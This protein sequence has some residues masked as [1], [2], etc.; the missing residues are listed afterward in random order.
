LELK[1]HASIIAVKSTSPQT[2]DLG[3]LRRIATE[4]EARLARISGSESVDVFGD[5]G[6]EVL[7]E[8]RPDVLAALGLSTGAVARQIEQSEAQ[9]P[10]GTLRD[11]DK[12]L[13]VDV[14]TEIDSLQR[15]ERVEIQYGP[16]GRTTRLA[17]IA[18]IQRAIVDPPATLALVDDVPAVVLGTL[19]RDDVRI[20]LWADRLQSELKLFREQLPSG[21]EVD[22]LFLQSSYVERSLVALLRNLTIGTLAVVV[23]VFFLLGWRSTIVVGSALPLAALMV[24][25][26]MRLLGIPIHQMSITGLVI[27]LGLLIDNAIV[28]VEEVRSRIW[29]G[30]SPSRAIVEAIRHLALP[31]FGSTMTTTL[32]FA[33]I[34]MLPGPPGEYVGAIAVSVILAINASFLLAMSIVP[35]LTALV[36]GPTGH[37][38]LLSYGISSR[39]MR[40]LYE[41]S[42]LFVFRFPLLGIVAAA[43]IP[44][45]GF[46]A[47]RSLPE[48]FFPPAER[49]Q[50]H[51]EV[52]MPVGTSLAETRATAQAIGNVV[53]DHQQVRRVHWFLGNSAPTFFYNVMPRRRNAPFYGQALID[54]HDDA[55]PSNVI[56][57]LQTQLDESFAGCRVLVRQLEQGPPFDAPVEVRIRGPDLA[58][59][60]QLGGRVRLL[61]SETH[62]VIHTRSDLEETLPNLAVRVEDAEVRAAGLT[63]LELTRQLYTAL[64]GAKAGSLIEAG[65]KLPIRV[66]AGDQGRMNIAQVAALELPNLVPLGP[67]RPPD[68][69]AEGA[70]PVVALAELELSSEVGSISRINGERVNE[71]KAYLTAGT[72]PSKV[73]SEFGR[74]FA[75][76]DF[77]LPTGYAIE[78]GGESA[79]RDEAVGNLLADAVV[80]FSLILVTLVLAFRSFRIA[81]IIA[82]VGGL[83]IG[84]GLASLWC[85]GY[86]IGFMAIIGTMGLVG[87]AINDAIVVMA[88]IRS[89]AAARAGDWSAMK[90]VINGCTRHVLATSL[91]TMAGFTPLLLAGGGFW[92]P[93]AVTIAGGIAG[94][95]L[96]AL[97]FVPCSYLLFMCRQPKI[98]PV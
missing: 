64:A 27:A 90:S 75:Q 53:A 22:V 61:L 57:D 31:L 14:A 96:L 38:T 26:G 58:T 63:S 50:I 83:A 92:P 67:P 17:N 1:A 44:L 19:I 74:R 39:L 69:A 18:D 91:T 71:V 48:Q 24:L 28:I 40:R 2:A 42:L 52:E 72:L 41:R 93:L 11:N 95:T 6:E 60:Q 35:A 21:V 87:V 30:L 37:R 33:P 12:E 13:L 16:M 49:D 62:D 78:Y 8:I 89:D 81:A 23:V 94:A 54:L 70:A 77:E 45:L 32:A 3:Q 65:E 34:A 73:V 9:H 7:V 76:S 84:L 51:V 46:V 85:F 43:L 68:S 29:N 82:A 80:L 98:V 25:S 5:P 88:A 47:G 10:A 79:K 4:L 66:R 15:L 20:D 56:Q 97:Y 86:P 55:R 36:Q 59:L